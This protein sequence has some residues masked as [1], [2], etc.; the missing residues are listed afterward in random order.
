M[1]DVLQYQTFSTTLVALN[2]EVYDMV[3][4]TKFV[5][6]NGHNTSVGVGEGWCVPPSPCARNGGKEK[7]S[8]RAQGRR[9]DGQERR[10]SPGG[11]ADW[12][13][14]GAKAGA[15]GGQ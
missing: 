1:E 12:K 13:G 3:S 10:R 14:V 6:L 15:H 5:V 11:G 7:R 8:R 2:E 9:S 4:T